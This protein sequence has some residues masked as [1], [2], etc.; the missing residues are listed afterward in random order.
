MWHEYF[1]SGLVVGLD[2]KPNPLKDMPE[3]MRFYQ[4]SQDDEALLEMIASECAP[5]GFDIVIDDASHIGRLARASYRH[6]FEKHVKQGGIYVVEDWGTGYWSSWPDGQGYPLFPVNRPDASAKKRSFLNKVSTKLG[7]A[8]RG[9]A[10]R[11]ASDPHFATHNFGMVGFV[12]ELFDEVAWP[13]ITSPGRGN[14]SLQ[15]R[16]A[17][18]RELTIYMGHAFV[19]KA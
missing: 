7:S 19:V 2:L 15:P 1:S 16:A 3:R 5:D 11:P 4:G 14:P 8:V 17:K 6:P 12:K 18:I 10:C 9:F 13:D